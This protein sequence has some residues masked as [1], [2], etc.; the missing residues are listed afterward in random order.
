[1]TIDFSKPIYDRL[2]AENVEVRTANVQLQRVH[3]KLR[4]HAEAMATWLQY[5]GRNSG[6]VAILRDYHAD[7]PEAP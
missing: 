1:M 3:A 5:G 4:K 6:R 2:V 7:F